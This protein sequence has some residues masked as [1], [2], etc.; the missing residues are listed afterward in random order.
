MLF[1]YHTRDWSGWI[2]WIYCTC[3]CLS[4][5][6]VISGWPCHIIT[7]W[8]FPGIVIIYFISRMW[9]SFKWPC[10]HMGWMN[11]LAHLS[12]K[13]YVALLR[14]CLRHQSCNP[15]VGKSWQWAELS[16]DRF[17]PLAT[18]FSSPRRYN[19][20][21]DIR[22]ASIVHF[23]TINVYNPQIMG[24][25]ARESRLRKSLYIYI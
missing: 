19:W 13:L 9:P 5:H 20:V 22:W 10:T 3:T 25:Y 8:S 23:R 14:S 1:I 2:Y 18:H 12:M 15:E 4:T 6:M 16:Q 21:P 17:L 7:K 11:F 24:R